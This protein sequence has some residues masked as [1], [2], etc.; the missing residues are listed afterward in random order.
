VRRIGHSALTAAV[1]ILG[2]GLPS[3]SVS[4][5]PDP[6]APP[7]K[8]LRHGELRS[9]VVQEAP[10]PPRFEAAIARPGP[11][12]VWIKGDWRHSG[13]EWGWSGGRWSVPPGPH[14]RWV[15]ASYEAVSGG[16]RYTPGHWSNEH[17]VKD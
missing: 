6:A 17:A 7:S 4:A 9:R 11:R 12:F 2:A 5:Q 13:H 14:A 1:L 15:P 8:H 16:T 10:P 3:G